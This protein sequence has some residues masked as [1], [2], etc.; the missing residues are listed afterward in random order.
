FRG[1]RLPRAAL[2]SLCRREPVPTPAPRSPPSCLADL[3]PRRRHGES[4]RLNSL[5]R[6]EVPARLSCLRG[7]YERNSSHTKSARNRRPPGPPTLAGLGGFLF[8]PPNGPGP[9]S[10]TTEYPAAPL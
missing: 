4:W 6:P 9:A 8:L 2:P 3:A 1:L 10:R 5:T 7:Q